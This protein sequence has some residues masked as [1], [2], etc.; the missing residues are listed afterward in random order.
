MPPK[1]FEGKFG[2]PASHSVD[3]ELT[4]ALYRLPESIGLPYIENLTHQIVEECNKRLEDSYEERLLGNAPGSMNL[5]SVRSLS[6]SHIKTLT[7]KLARHFEDNGESAKIDIPTCIDALVESPRFLDSIKGSM[8]KL[9]EIHEMK[10]LQRIAELRKKRAEMDGNESYNPYENLFETSDGKYYMERLLNMPHLEEESQYMDH[11]VGTSTSYV[12]KIKRGEV[13][14]LSFR[15]KETHNPVVTI[16]YDLKAKRLLQVKSQSDV[17][18]TLANDYAPD[19]LEVLTSLGSTINDQGQPRVVTN[20]VVEHMT[21]LKALEEKSHQQKSFTRDEL[22]FLYEINEGIECFDTDREPL[23]DIL[24][25]QRNRQEDI[26]TLCNCP[27][28]YIAHDFIEIT[29][30]TQVFCE[31]DGNK[32]TFFDF[33][34]DKNKAKLPQLLELAQKIKETGSPARPDMEFGSIVNC[35]IPE[36]DAKDMAALVKSFKEADNGSP[37]YIWPEWSKVPFT[38]PKSPSFETVVLSYNSDPT[39]RKSSDKI[40]EDMDKLGLRPLTLEEMTI[41]GIAYP[42]FTKTSNKYFVGLTKYA[43]D[44][45]SFVPSLYRNDDERRL[46]GNGWDDEWN[47]RDRFLCVRK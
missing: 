20:K 30:S 28:E 23:I 36:S 8:D 7:L 33:R 15:D 11:C 24:L 17:I 1:K 31:D 44:G 16:E 21:Q 3:S 14:I 32:I 12:N 2:I 26:L 9:F 34:E 46:D 37:D 41:A 19:L 39:T 5:K 35:T 29:E 10:T 47:D 25:S 38:Q 45:D 43:L 13:E 6:E 40:A 27:P 18:P 42:T 22:L 4:S